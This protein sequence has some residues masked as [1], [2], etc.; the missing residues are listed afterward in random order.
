MKKILAVSFFVIFCCLQS[1][2]LAKADCVADVLIVFTKPEMVNKMCWEL[3]A[4]VGDDGTPINPAKHQI[5]G[6]TNGRFIVLPDNLDPRVVAHELNHV[7]ERRCKGDMILRMIKKLNKGLK[8][9]KEDK[10]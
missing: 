6:C 4:K 1:L 9:R 2:P 3:G 8:D 10:K 7:V 5:L